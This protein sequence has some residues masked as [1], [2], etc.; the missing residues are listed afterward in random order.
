M[1]PS[2]CDECG[3][4][5]RDIERCDS[6]GHPTALGATLER[7][8]RKLRDDLLFVVQ[9]EEKTRRQAQVRL[10]TLTRTAKH[11]LLWG[12]ASL[13]TCCLFIPGI[14][15]VVLG[16]RACAQSLE[17][18]VPL[19]RLALVGS[20]LG[21]AAI[22]LGLAVIALGAWDWKAREDRVTAIDRELGVTASSPSLDT[23]AA[24]LLAE[25]SLLVEGWHRERR[26][27]EIECRGSSVQEGDHA[28]V[29]HV[30]FQIDGERFVATACLARTS[31]GVWTVTG[32]RDRASCLESDDTRPSMSGRYR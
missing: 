29:S 22:T 11:S 24:C 23:K 5:L 16:R 18:R 3:R 6:C 30:Q 9:A 12:I 27:R 14:V 1:L 8:D 19:P 26:V 32:F 17:L 13:P 28:N 4:T 7:R 31:A 20:I 21:G 25:R 15:A 10:E 2:V